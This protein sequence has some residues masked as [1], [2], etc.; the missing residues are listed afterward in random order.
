MNRLRLSRNPVGLLLSPAPSAAFR[1][2]F[3]YLFTGA[4][5]TLPV[6]YQH[7]HQAFTTGVNGSSSSSA[8]GVQL[9]YFPHGPHATDC[10]R[11]RGSSSWA[12]TR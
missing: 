12:G 1:Y 10:P 8:H 9:G 2:L 6:W 5:I 7:P 11:P 4:G 3:A